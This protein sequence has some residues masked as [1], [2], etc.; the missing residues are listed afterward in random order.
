MA[1]FLKQPKFFIP[2][3]VIAS[4]ALIFAIQ[5]SGASSSFLSGLSFA[6]TI[7]PVPTLVPV[8]EAAYKS[9]VHSPDGTMK[10]VLDKVFK[11]QTSID[12]IVTV[13]KITGTDKKVILT[14][15]FGENQTIQLPQNSFSPDNKYIFLKEKDKDMFSFYVYKVSG[16]LFANGKEYTEV[17]PLFEDKKYE[18]KL[19]DVTGWDSNTLLH[20]FTVKENGA[21]GP[22]FW[23]DTENYA[24]YQLGHR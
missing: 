3:F 9:E 13:S 14:K 18:L 6:D 12:H 16:E 23:F 21:A 5:L 15:T 24:F 8:K 17:I 2:T 22:S 11:S 10:I 19:S 20:I 1:N 4:L 7:F